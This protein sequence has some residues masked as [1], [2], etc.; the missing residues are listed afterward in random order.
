[1]YGGKRGNSGHNGD[2][3]DGYKRHWDY[4]EEQESRY[5]V[6]IQMPSVAYCRTII[7]NRWKI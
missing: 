2:G 4:N 6:S 1:M 7:S 5:F 3:D